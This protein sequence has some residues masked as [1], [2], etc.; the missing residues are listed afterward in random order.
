MI[1][2]G[3][4]NANQ[5]CSRYAELSAQRFLHH[6]RDIR[7][8]TLHPGDAELFRSRRCLDLV[9][10]VLVVREPA[11]ADE[12]LAFTCVVCGPK[13]SA[14]SLE[15]AGCRGRNGEAGYS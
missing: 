1:H 5:R 7:A 14:C 11:G 13:E 2:M 3:T 6:L 9:E 10:N 4:E 8:A 12:T 15:V